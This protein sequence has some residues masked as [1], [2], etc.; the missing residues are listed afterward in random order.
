MTSGS[1][2]WAHVT[3]AAQLRGEL[4]VPGDKSLSHRALLFNALADGEAVVSGIGWGED[5]RSSHRCLEDLG[6]GR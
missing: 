5:V 6:V 1:A 4:R 2:A 3:P